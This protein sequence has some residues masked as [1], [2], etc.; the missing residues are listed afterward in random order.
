MVM[1]I[2]VLA[3]KKREYHQKTVREKT[4]EWLSDRKESLDGFFD[5]NDWTHGRATMLSGLL[6]AGFAVL[7]Y[8]MSFAGAVKDGTY[9]KTVLDSGRTVFTDRATGEVIN[10]LNV[11]GSGVTFARI[12]AALA[13]LM[14]VVGLIEIIIFR[15]RDRKYRQ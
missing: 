6:I 7:V 11:Q 4:K 1:I 8:A 3:M 2:E 13:L 9:V 5:E 12:I 10:L 15:A 14:L